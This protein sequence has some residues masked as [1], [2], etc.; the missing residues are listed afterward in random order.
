MK[1]TI[2][3]TTLLALLM[4]V[5]ACSDHTEATATG[6]EEIRLGAMVNQ[7]TPTR[8]ATYEHVYTGAT[9]W[10]WADNTEGETIVEA[11]Y[12]KA[13]QLTA[14][15]NGSMLPAATDKKLWP[16][17]GELNFY[18]LIGNFPE[19]TFVGNTT[20]FPTEALTHTIAADQTTEENYNQS[21]LLY[22]TLTEVTSD[23]YPMIQFQHMLTQV[24][25]ALIAGGSITQAQLANATVELEG[26]PVSA[27]LTLSKTET[28]VITASE[29]TNNV[30]ISTVANANGSNYNY[31]VAI[32]APHSVSGH[33]VKV[34]YDTK[35]YYYDVNKELLSGHT[36]KLNLKLTDNGLISLGEAVISGWETS[37]N[38]WTG[39]GANAGS[40]GPLEDTTDE[41]LTLQALSAGEV[42]VRNPLAKS[43]IYQVNGGQ[44]ITTSDTWFSVAVPANG[45]VS[46]YGENNTYAT[47]SSYTNIDS[48]VDCYIYGNIMSLIKSVAYPTTVTLPS[49]YTFYGLFKN[50]RRLLSHPTKAL[51]LPATSIRENCYQSMFQGCVKLTIPPA[52]PATTLQNSCYRDMFNGCSSLIAAPELLAASMRE[53]CYAGMFRDCKNLRTAPELSS[54]SLNGYCYQYMFSGCTNLT[55]APELPATSLNGYCYQ[56]MFS[57]CTGL[58]KAP[59]L[60]AMSISNYCYQYMFSGCTSLTEAPDLP[61]TTIKDYCYGYMFQDC[62]SLTEAPDL[63]A[64]TLTQ[65]CYTGMFKGCTGLTKAP[66]LPATTTLKGCY[67]SMFMNCTSLTEAPDLPATTAVNSCYN[68]MFRGCTSLTEA[69][70]L[71]ATT[72]DQYCY[73]DMFNGCTNLASVPST[74]PAM[75]VYYRSYYSMF[76]GCSALTT[77]PTLPAT[78]MAQDC[79]YNMFRNCTSL[80]SAPTLPA[81]TMAIYC[82]DGMFSGCTSLTEAPALPATTLANYCYSSMFSGCTSLVVA[83][84]LPVMNLTTSCY[85][86][87][88]YNCTSLQEAPALP[89]TSLTSSCYYAMFYNCTSLQTAPDLPATSL[90]ASCYRHMFRGCSSLSY[91]KCMAT[92]IGANLC[93]DLFLEGVAPNGTFVKN[94]NMNN[95]TTG[96]NGIPEGWTVTNAN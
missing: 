71:P 15:A 48:N 70:D 94:P 61:A 20:P 75:T 53:Y 65:Y 35:E 95:W 90:A 55:T 5:M 8:A 16:G 30:Q 52:L 96:V 50:N 45:T 36:Y 31:A 47:S 2:Y 1:K 78:T 17:S 67:H 60:N 56:Y 80:T 86:A 89:A 43:I 54:T 25:V 68:A 18:A 57:G 76:E 82:Y 42:I 77:A 19:E 85:S 51:L 63:P 3:M 26:M 83:P 81:L 69:P 14:N 87:M 64:E 21:D 58:T 22:G 23:E 7:L 37:D 93:T 9:C 12:L 39:S 34:T 10:V 66:D 72:I 41:P 74:L 44:K 27:S 38:P 29:E 11:D 40:F 92:S 49:T 24:Q 73:N 32:V 46:F 13:W 28:P 91:I 79:Y 4:T 84:A 88:F 59:D 33:F 6:G 62:T